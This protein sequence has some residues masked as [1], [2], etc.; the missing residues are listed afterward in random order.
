[1]MSMR[2][3]L[4]GRPLAILYRHAKPTRLNLYLWGYDKKFIATDLST[5]RIGVTGRDLSKKIFY[6]I[7]RT[8]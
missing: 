7:E 2:V 6:R 1:M 3:K 4:G 5:K 8:G